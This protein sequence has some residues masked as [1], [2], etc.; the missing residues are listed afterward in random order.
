MLRAAPTNSYIDFDYP[1]SSEIGTIKLNVPKSEEDKSQ[2]Q[3]NYD[4]WDLT[5][6]LISSKVPIGVI[7]VTFII[8][9]LIR[10]YT[11]A[12]LIYMAVNSHSQELIW[13]LVIVI[14]RFL[15]AFMV[16]KIS[17]ETPETRTEIVLKSH[18][19]SK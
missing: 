8:F 16:V 14:D 19:N 10:Y 15:Y 3:N 1:P 17:L 18:W 5:Y 4:M 9:V 12:C 11:V 13:I 7:T 6:T 2:G